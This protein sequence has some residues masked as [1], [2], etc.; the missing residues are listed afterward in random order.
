MVVSC[1]AS[2]PYVIVCSCACVLSSFSRVQLF[3]TRWTVA[4]QDPLSAGFSRQEYWS[5]L[6]CPPAGDFPDLG[7][8]PASFRSP[9]LAGG[10]F[11]T[12][13]TWEA[14]FAPINPKFPVN[15]SPS[16]PPILSTTSLF[17]MSMSLFLFHR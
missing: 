17:S 7:I 10:F 14:Q 11:T 2:V 13:T 8:K 5:G 9:G 6:P 12:G 16:L 3:A 4:H 1:Y 15:P